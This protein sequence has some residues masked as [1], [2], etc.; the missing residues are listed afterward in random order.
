MR[1][2]NMDNMENVLYFKQMLESFNRYY[3]S[4]LRPLKLLKSY[5]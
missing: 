2:K 1:V 4:R 3:G 5:S